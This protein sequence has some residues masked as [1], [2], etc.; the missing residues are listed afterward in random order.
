MCANGPYLW[1]VTKE[2]VRAFLNRKLGFLGRCIAWLGSNLPWA[3]SQP[4]QGEELIAVGNRGAMSVRSVHGSMPCEVAS[5]RMHSARAKSSLRLGSVRQNQIAAEPH[6]LS[7]PPLPLLILPSVATRSSGH[8]EGKGNAAAAAATPTTPL[9]FIAVADRADGAGG[10]QEELGTQQAVELP[11]SVSTEGHDSPQGPANGAHA[12]THTHAGSMGIEAMPHFHGLVMP[13]LSTAAHPA[14]SSP[15]AAAAAVAAA[16][17]SVGGSGSGSM[18]YGALLP[19]ATAAPVV[20]RASAPA[21]VLLTVRGGNEGMQ[22]ETAKTVS[23]AVMLVS[24]TLGSTVPGSSG[25]GD[26]SAT[27]S[28]N[29]Q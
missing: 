1:Q 18:V 11:G 27:T 23:D 21:V 26:T 16:R 28:S 5:M 29:N 15:A 19:P 10:R 13:S 4:T 14:V 9:A 7:S 20:D 3:R 17:P 6:T 24:A 22:P 12:H 2:E 25:C 8:G